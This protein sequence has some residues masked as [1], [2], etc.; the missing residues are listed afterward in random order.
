VLFY[1]SGIVATLQG[2]QIPRH[3]AK[4]FD[5]LC[6]AEVA[7]CWV[8]G[9]AERHGSDISRVRDKASA[10]ITTAVGLKHSVGSP[11]AMPS[12]AATKGS[13]T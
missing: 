6:I 3:V 7:G 12:S 11:A 1:F 8:A 13:A 4:L 2:S 9:P 5:S 10:R